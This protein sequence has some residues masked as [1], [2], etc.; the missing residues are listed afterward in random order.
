MADTAAQ[1]A[2]PSRASPAPRA[3]DGTRDD[4]GSSEDEDGYD[5]DKLS[6]VPQCH[7]G[8]AL[9]DR[10]HRP[11]MYAY[12]QEDSRGD[13]LTASAE[14]DHGGPYRGD[15]ELDAD[16]DAVPAHGPGSP[17]AEPPDQFRHAY[18]APT[19]ATI[20]LS[21]ASTISGDRHPGRGPDRRSQPQG[22]VRMTEAGEQVSQCVPGDGDLDGTAERH[23]RHADGGGGRPGRGLR[24]SGL[25]SVLR[26]VTVAEQQRI[27]R[28]PV[29]S[30]ADRQCPGLAEVAAGH[31]DLGGCSSSTLAGSPTPGSLARPVPYVS[32]AAICGS[33]ASNAAA[34]PAA[35]PRPATLSQERMCRLPSVQAAADQP[36]AASEIRAWCRAAPQLRISCRPCGSPAVSWRLR[37][38]NRSRRSGYPPPPRFG[39]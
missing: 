28:G 9:Q 17:S 29:V 33:P 37:V 6:T 30:G 5:R 20:R 8:R 11:E 32:S 21:T 25:Q 2:K 22:E 18:T 23:H 19:T 26:S 7:Q 15:A 27:D 38:A 36:S 1:L 13:V 16:D 31:G 14:G 34:R 4:G 3:C 35:E 39:C 10:C 24:L 12:H